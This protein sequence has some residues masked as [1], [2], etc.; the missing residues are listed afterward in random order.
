[1][2]RSVI[3]LPLPVS[4]S[5]NV[6]LSDTIKRV[7]R[8]SVSV[9]LR[10]VVAARFIVGAVTVVGVVLL[11]SRFMSL[12]DD[13][14]QQQQ[15]QHMATGKHQTS[16]VWYNP[17]SKPLVA[18]EPRTRTSPHSVTG[19]DSESRLNLNPSV[20][21]ST[22]VLTPKLKE[23]KFTVVISGFYPRRIPL[24]AKT[25]ELFVSHTDLVE[26]ILVVWDNAQYPAPTFRPNQNHIDKRNAIVPVRVISTAGSSFFHRWAVAAKHSPTEACMF[27]D[28]DTS[29]A[30]INE[31]RILFNTFRSFP[32]SAIGTEARTYVEDRARYIFHSSK[33][34][35]NMV[36]P[37][38][39]LIGRSTLAKFVALPGLQHIIDT[40]AAHCDDIAL[41]MYISFIV[42]LPVV[43]VLDIRV[44]SYNDFTNGAGFR[45]PIRGKLRSDCS[46][47][48]VQY[49]NTSSR[50]Y[51]G[52]DVTDI[53]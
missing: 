44:V 40:Q 28:D 17:T 26:A 3:P 32:D 41:N 47:E 15:Q 38:P 22:L 50:M 4:T 14:Q 18:T 45:S 39:F 46:R 8:P 10:L 12:S 9:S 37:R 11:Y 13:Y 2:L 36:L 34:A 23:K 53:P 31:A 24:I 52:I 5:D 16:Y 19:S 42:H 7:S 25:I 49:F 1:M 20:Q 6:V 21:Y 30:T 48:L 51:K 29:L 27:F 43:R 33:V 35:W